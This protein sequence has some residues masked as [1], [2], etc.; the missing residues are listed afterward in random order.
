LF[1]IGASEQCERPGLERTGIVWLGDPSG[2][3]HAGLPPEHPLCEILTAL[4]KQFEFV[5][6]WLLCRSL[7]AMRPFER[8][9]ALIRL[10]NSNWE[11]D[12]TASGLLR[13]RRSISHDQPWPYPSNPGLRRPY[14]EIAVVGNRFDHRQLQVEPR[15]LTRAIEGEELILQPCVV[16]FLVSTGSYAVCVGRT[17]TDNSPGLSIIG[18]PGLR[19]EVLVPEHLLLAV[20]KGTD[21]ERAW[22]YRRVAKV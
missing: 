9:S 21:A 6:S 12:D 2:E 4:L 16:E 18:P 17:H 22:S 13:A 20:H 19:P 3:T 1:T 8:S 5:G 7:A 15:S 14:S 10:T 11:I